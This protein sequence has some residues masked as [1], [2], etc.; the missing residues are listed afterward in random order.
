[1]TT[2]NAAGFAGMLATG[3]VAVTLAANAAVRTSVSMIVTSVVCCDVCTTDVL[4]RV[5]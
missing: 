1:M 4:A 5:R 3:A 2:K